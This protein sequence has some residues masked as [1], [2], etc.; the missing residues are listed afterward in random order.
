MTA[1]L[2]LG[3]IRSGK[4]S[5]AEQ[6]ILE[7]SGPVIYVATATIEDAEM[8][9][10]VRLHKMHRPAQ[11]WLEEEPLALGS[12][13]RRKALLNPAPSL[14]IDCMSLW[15]SNL[16]HAGDDVFTRER[17]SFLTA[18]VRYPGKVVIVSN[19]VGWGTIGMDPLTRR[20]AD[21][22][23]W[24]NQALAKRCD[25]VMLSIAGIPLTLKG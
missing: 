21:E 8:R 16:L 24:L 18:L 20:F 6:L 5:L 7:Q 11:W 9:E 2:V 25:T 12:I 19:E 22:L 10:R 14:L 13:L 4:S 3:G 15:V 23:G 17:D 1:T